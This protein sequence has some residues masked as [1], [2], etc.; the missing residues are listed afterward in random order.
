MGCSTLPFSEHPRLTG[1]L[2]QDQLMNKV[3]FF[4]AELQRQQTYQRAIRIN[5]VKRRTKVRAAC[6]NGQAAPVPYLSLPALS[7]VSTLIFTFCA[8]RKVAH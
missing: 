1:K 6:F 2:P 5:H 8:R 7:S 3:S 4:R